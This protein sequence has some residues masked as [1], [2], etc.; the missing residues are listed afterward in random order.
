MSHIFTKKNKCFQDAV[1][2]C[3]PILQSVFKMLCNPILQSVNRFFKTTHVRL[4][5]KGW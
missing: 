4:R 5:N 3:S 2:S 1:Q